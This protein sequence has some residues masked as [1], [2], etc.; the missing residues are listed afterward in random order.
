MDS[1]LKITM[2]EG[3]YKALPLEIRSQMVLEVVEVEFDYSS[4]PLW[5]ELKKKSREAY[6]ALKEREFKLR[7]P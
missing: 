3:D 5:N 6:K 2:R 7:H 4:D 1:T